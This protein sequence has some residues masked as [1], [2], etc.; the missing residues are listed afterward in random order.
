MRKGD[1]IAAFCSLERT[2]NKDGERHFTGAWSDRTRAMA[3]N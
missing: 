2:Y 1:L 3:S